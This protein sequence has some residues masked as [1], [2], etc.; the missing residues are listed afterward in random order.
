[1]ESFEVWLEEYLQP[2]LNKKQR[3]LGKTLKAYVEHCY[4]DEQKWRSE[5]KARDAIFKIN[6]VWIKLHN[7]RLKMD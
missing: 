3:D 4:R 5:S 2:D 7:P 1:L 6:S